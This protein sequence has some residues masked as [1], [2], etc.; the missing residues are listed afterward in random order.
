MFDSDEFDR[1]VH[2]GAQIYRVIADKFGEPPTFNQLVFVFNEYP[3]GVIN[4]TIVELLQIGAIIEE[5]GVFSPAP[6]AHG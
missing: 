1:G 2:L 4:R 5:D 3:E 6:D